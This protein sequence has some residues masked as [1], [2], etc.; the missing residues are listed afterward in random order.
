MTPSKRALARQTESPSSLKKRKQLTMDDY[1]STVCTLTK[2]V[3]FLVDYIVS[4][5]VFIKAVHAIVAGEEK[6]IMNICSILRRISKG[7]LGF[8]VL[9]DL[10]VAQ[11]WQL[12][13]RLA[14]QKP[15]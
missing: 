2:C 8:K 6:K 9:G 13:A 14:F 15:C 11:T 4:C 12:M 10:D 3:I 1:A 7:L 5:C